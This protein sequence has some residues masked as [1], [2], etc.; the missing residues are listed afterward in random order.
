MIAAAKRRSTRHLGGIFLVVFPAQF[1]FGMWLNARGFQS[2]DSLYRSVNA[3]QVLHGSDP[4]L[5]AIGL[6]WMP[7]PT[8]LQLPWTAVYP[9]WPDVVSSGASASLTTSLAGGA[10]AALLLATCT[11]LGLSARLGWAYA[12]LVSANPMLFLYSANGLSEGVSAPFLIGAVCCLTLFWHSGLRRYVGIAG[13]SL[14][15]GFA[16]LYEAVPF[17]AALFAALVGGVISDSEARASAPQGRWRA[18]EGLGLV[19]LVPS[20]FVAALWLLAN[21]VIMRDP[22]FFAFGPYSNH[23]QTKDAE[24]FVFDLAGDAL[25]TLAFVCERSA[26]FLIPIGFVLLVRLLDGRLLRVNTVAV[27]LLSAS[28]PFGLIAPL[29]YGHASFGWLRFFVY[30]LFVAAG[31]GLYEVATSRRPRRAASLVIAG[32]ALAF[33]AT[34]LAMSKPAVGQEEHVVVKALVRGQGAQDVGHDN[35]LIY[36]RPVAR[37]LA[38]G[39]LARGQRVL[40][41]GAWPLLALARPSHLLTVLIQASDRRFRAMLKDPRR[42]RVSYLLVQRPGTTSDALA[43]ARPRLWTGEEPGF[44]LVK[45]FSATPEH[46]RL[47]EVERVPT[48]TTAARPPRGD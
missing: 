29:V 6:V 24:G 19:L 18:L 39:P 28:V 15:L 33:P 38:A 27:L 23:A 26:P 36:M 42:H 3:L 10:T 16:S 40:F 46:W 17:G 20:F 9:L 43:R 7:L 12:L 45:S 25:G 48:R 32:W 5:G 41:D 37:Y 47:Y 8:L 22:L 30:V 13:V 4:H 2:S 44:R 14:A 11:R 34:L 21:A 31:W 35:P 1:A